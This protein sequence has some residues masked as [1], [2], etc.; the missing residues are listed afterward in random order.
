MSIDVDPYPK[1][2]GVA[3]VNVKNRVATDANN[4]LA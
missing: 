2:R 1:K 3:V 4:M